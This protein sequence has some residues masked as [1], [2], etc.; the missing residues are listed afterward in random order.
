MNT[1]NNTASSI[2]VSRARTARSSR[3]RFQA[4]GEPG[5]QPLHRCQTTRWSRAARSPASGL[6]TLILVDPTAAI[7]VAQAPLD[8]RLNTFNGRSGGGRRRSSTSA[9]TAVD[10]N[11]QAD[12]QPGCPF[13]KNLVAAAIKAIV[14]AYRAATDLQYV[15]VIG[16]DGVIPFYR[17]PDPALLGN[18]TLY[19]P[20]VL[21][22]SPRRRASGSATY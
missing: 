13:A 4:R 20:P 17:Y 18:E 19:M 22:S 10:L 2:S 15:V 12:D 1:W 14:D 3:K 8:T 9:L 21:D 6:R 5:G 16:G 7:A 11:D